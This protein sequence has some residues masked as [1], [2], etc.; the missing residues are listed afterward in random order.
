MEEAAPHQLQ[1]VLQADLAKLGNIHLSH[2]L[3]SKA[4]APKHFCAALP[5][6]P[7]G[8]CKEE[9]VLVMQGLVAQA[10]QAIASGQ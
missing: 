8:L 4:K 5:P 3:E 1:E 2:I 10:V 6:P 7:A 9:L